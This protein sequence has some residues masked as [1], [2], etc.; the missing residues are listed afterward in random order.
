M[1]TGLRG[2][3]AVEP[4]AGSEQCPAPP[5]RQS[6]RQLAAAGTMSLSREKLCGMIGS[7]RVSARFLSTTALTLF[8]V[9]SANLPE[10]GCGLKPCG[11]PEA[12]K[13]SS[14]VAGELDTRRNRE[15][16]RAVCGQ[17]DLVP[18]A[19]VELSDSLESCII[20]RIAVDLSIP[21]ERGSETQ[22]AQRSTLAMS[23]AIACAVL[24]VRRANSAMRQGAPG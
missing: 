2:R 15:K 4:E 18:E 24:V 6:S 22:E 3:G 11:W 17:V 7:E 14:A 8:D 13:L 16:R 5:S 19:D 10:G 9:E 20:V 21:S 1:E 12:S 23:R